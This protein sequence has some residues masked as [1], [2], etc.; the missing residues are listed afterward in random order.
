MTVNGRLRH[1]HVL[2]AEK[3]LGRPLPKGAIV[4]HVTENGLDNYGPFK[5]I[6][7]PNQYYHA[8][9]H[10]AMRDEG[11][12]FKTGWPNG[13]VRIDDKLKRDD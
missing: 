8:R 7:C 1:E 9:M 13:P 10:K 3:A 4:H 6:I 5:L 11:I 2:I 12:S